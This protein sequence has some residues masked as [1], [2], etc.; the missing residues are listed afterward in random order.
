MIPEDQPQTPPDLRH[1]NK[2]NLTTDLIKSLDRFFR[3][4]PHEIQGM[5]QSICDRKKWT[6]S[7]LAAVIL[8]NYSDLRD[9][10]IGKTKPPGVALRMIWHLYMMDTAP[11]LAFSILHV[12]TWGKIDQLPAPIIHHIKGD[13]RKR[14]VEELRN[15]AERL[16]LGQIA[17]RYRTNRNVAG[18]LCDEAKYKPMREKQDKRTAKVRLR[19]LEPESPWMRL[20]WRKKPRDL[21]E[22]IRASEPTIKLNLSR[23]RHLPKR[24][25]LRH[26][27]ACGV[28]LTKWEP[29]LKYSKKINRKKSQIVFDQIVSGPV[30]SS[31]NERP[32]TE[33]QSSNCDATEGGHNQS[34]APQG[35]EG[36]TALQLHPDRGQQEVSG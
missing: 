15:C 18:D 35:E 1:I 2:T 24:V 32:V 34:E 4:G 11:A 23:L 5:I 36:D 7:Y 20:D 30:A 16:T 25:L 10:E 3:P 9:W 31:G 22:D 33:N 6:R 26:L 8:V 28:D 17:E 14:V 12:A 27:K 21:V 13:E 29:I 19:I